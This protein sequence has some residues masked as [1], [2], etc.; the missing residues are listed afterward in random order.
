MKQ[1]SLAL[2]MLWAFTSRAQLVINEL[3]SDTQSVDDREFVEL[4]SSAPNFSLDGFALVFFNGSADS[5]RSYYAIDLDGYSTDVNGIFV[6]GN[7]L[8]SPVPQM[9]MPINIIQNGPDAVAIYQADASDFPNDTPATQNN[10]IHAL[11]YGTS[12]PDPV[13]LMEMLGVTFQADE[14]F[15]NQKDFHSVQRKADG[16]YEAKIPTPGA[17]NDGSGFVFNGISMSL[18][19]PMINE[20][21]SFTVT[22]TALNDV[23]DDLEFAI[24]LSNGGFNTDDFTGSLQVLIPAGMTSTTRTFT[25]VDDSLDEGDELAVIKFGSLP[26]GFNRTNDNL[27]VRVIDNDFYTLPF[28]TPLNPTYGVVSSTAPEG[29]YASLEGKAGDELFAA[30]RAI[31]ANPE[32]V[33]A[34]TYGDTETILRQSDQNPQNSNQVWLMYVEEP[35]AKYKFQSTASNVDSWNR[36]H[37]FPQSRGGFA[38]A[39]SSWPD[40]INLWLPTS[41]SDIAAGH[42]DAHHIRAE[43]G[44]ENSARSNRDYGTDYNGPA[45]NLGSWKGDVARALFYMAVRYEGLTLVN[46]NPPDNIT[47]QMADL[48]SLLVWNTQDPS[49]DFEMNRNNIIYQWQYNRNPFIDYPE[50]ADYIWGTQQG[51]PWFAPLSNAE[52]SM[53]GVV[54]YPQPATSAF[55]VTGMSGSAQVYSMSGQ[56][57]ASFEFV[58]N[59]TVSHNLPTGVYILR[60][61]D[62]SRVVTKRLLVR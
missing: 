7:A 4:K 37:I 14:N 31:I 41:A 53:P 59:Q 60:L 30:L 17:N 23:A 57:V 58:E 12:D 16:T 42:S 1:F 8:V 20:G 35:M 29:Y 24:S 19:S 61:Q 56:Q 6:V 54:V 15:F 32:L 28:G 2:L 62:D 55:S 51:Q 50:L 27:E 49:D 33:R 34:H 36:E 22:F 11:V 45:G 48:A 39:T 13:A 25:V 5:N 38:N 21:D 18:S 52:F 3:D 46:G 43:D 44:P 26:F 9:L 40:G 10:L 47:G